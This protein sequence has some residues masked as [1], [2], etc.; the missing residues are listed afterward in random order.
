[1]SQFSHG[2]VLSPTLVNQCERS[3]E[4]R[5]SATD[6]VMRRVIPS[7]NS[8]V[9]VVLRRTVMMDQMLRPCLNL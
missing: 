3:L 9:V 1:M 5:L 2:S 4:S 6:T 7:F 8:L